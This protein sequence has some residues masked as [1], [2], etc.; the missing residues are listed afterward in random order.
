MMSISRRMRRPVSSTGT[1]CWEVLGWLL[2]AG[3]SCL[4]VCLSHSHTPR[5]SPS[6]GMV[7]SPYFGPVHVELRVGRLQMLG[8]WEPQ[9]VGQAVALGKG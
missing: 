6:L 5:D 8:R 4:S 3:R 1:A 9:Q 7:L 2:L